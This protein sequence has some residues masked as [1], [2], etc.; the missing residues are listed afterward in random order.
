MVK[1]RCTFVVECQEGNKFDSLCY[2]SGQAFFQFPAIASF[3]KIADQDEDGFRRSGYEGL[4]IGNSAV[5][6]S[7]APQL[8]AKND[9]D[10]VGQ[11]FA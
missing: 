7:A 4:Y 9:I 11:F 2:Y 1:C 5:Y 8:G 10:G 6:I 3:V